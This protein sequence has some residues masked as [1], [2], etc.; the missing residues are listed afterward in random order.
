MFVVLLTY[1]QSLDAVDQHVDAHRA[2]L[3]RHFASGTFLLSGRKDPRTG[4]VILADAASVGALQA[5]LAEDP[6]HVHGIATY[7]LVQFTPTMAAPALQML[8]AT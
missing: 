3:D 8:V 5:L 2:F 6:F 1:T 4:G 7:E